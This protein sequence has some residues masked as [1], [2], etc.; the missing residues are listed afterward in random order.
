MKATLINSLM[1][2]KQTLEVQGGIMSSEEL[3]QFETNSYYREAVQLRKY[4]DNGKVANKTIHP[5]THYQSL[6]RSLIK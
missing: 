4:D 6:I 1:H 3:A 2:R 5:V